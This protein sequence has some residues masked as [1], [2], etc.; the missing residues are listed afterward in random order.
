MYKCAHLRLIHQIVN[1]IMSFGAPAGET[2]END[3]YMIM[4]LAHSDIAAN[5]M[6]LSFFREN[7]EDYGAVCALR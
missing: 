1:I 4:L 2:W 7:D 3:E 6:T 5:A